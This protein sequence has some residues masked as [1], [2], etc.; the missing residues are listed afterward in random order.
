M[1]PGIPSKNHEKYV[2]KLNYCES[3]QKGYEE[4]ILWK[5]AAVSGISHNALKPR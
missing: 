5:F 2:K 4:K 3:T 1:C